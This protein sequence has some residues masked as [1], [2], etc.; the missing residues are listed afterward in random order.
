MASIIT[1]QA[2]FETADFTSQ[3]FIK[4]NNL[5]GMGN[6]W[7]RPNKQAGIDKYGLGVYNS[8]EDSIQDFRLYYMYKK[9]D[10]VYA[11]LDSYIEDLKEKKYFTADLDQYLAGVKVYYKKYFNGL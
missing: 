9:L 1:S 5:F 11:S 4:N 10:P 3:A 7:Q 2:A 8:I 6:A